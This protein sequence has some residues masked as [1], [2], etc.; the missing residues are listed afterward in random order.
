M[1][2]G[3]VKCLFLLCLFLSCCSPMTFTSSFSR[4]FS[5]LPYCFC[6]TLIN[7]LHPFLIFLIC[8]LL[9]FLSLLSSRFPLFFPPIFVPLLCPS[10]HSLLKV[11]FLPFVHIT[12]FQ[13]LTSFLPYLPLIPFTC[14]PYHYFSVHVHPSTESC[15]KSFTCSRKGA[16]CVCRLCREVAVI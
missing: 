15:L 13:P 8:F 1:I 4:Y 5:A 2:F 6:F 11:F 10:S 16:P 3:K 12:C 14:V 9:L 7:L